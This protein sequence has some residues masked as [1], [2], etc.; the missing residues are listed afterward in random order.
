[1]TYI[2]IELTSFFPKDTKISFLDISIYHLYHGSLTKRYYVS[3][4]KVITNFLKKKGFLFT[5][6]LV[7]N[8]IGLLEW[9]DN[10]RNEINHILQ[11]YFLQRRDDYVE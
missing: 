10:I 5:D 2:P 8:S 6:I 1:M 3:K 7:T 9:E 4:H 11:E